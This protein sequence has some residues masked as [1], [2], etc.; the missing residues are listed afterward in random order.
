M[1]VKKVIEMR[2][3]PGYE[4]S[5]PKGFYKTI[6]GNLTELSAFIEVS[7]TNEEDLKKLNDFLGCNV[8][9]VNNAT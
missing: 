9:M 8:S 3:T 1:F 4:V 5:D 7:L 2:N 6:P